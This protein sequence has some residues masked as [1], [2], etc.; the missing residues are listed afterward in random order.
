MRDR[1]KRDGFAMSIERLITLALV[2]AAPATAGYAAS[3]TGE[4]DRM[5][6][7]VNT[8]LGTVAQTGQSA[9]QSPAAGKHRQPTPSSIAAAE[10]GLGRLSPATIEAVKAAMARAREADHAGDQS[11][12]LH[13]LAEVQRLIG[14]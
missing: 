1:E 6:A 2:L 11:A 5:M 9:P 4:I 13:S 7:R 10:S 12:C 3:C 8:T 14:P